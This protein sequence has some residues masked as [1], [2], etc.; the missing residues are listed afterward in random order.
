V[1]ADRVSLL[2]LDVDIRIADIWRE[3]DAVG[4]WDL[5]HVAAFMRAAYG[6]GYSDALLEPRRG[7][8]CVD[9]GYRV[10]DRRAAA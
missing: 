1:N 3:A 5:E 4:A 2:E 10:P 6:R 8:L 9:H 7:L